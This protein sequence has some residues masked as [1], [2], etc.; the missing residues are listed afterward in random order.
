MPEYC[1]LNDFVGLHQSRKFWIYAIHVLIYTS[2]DNI[3]VLLYN[4]YFCNFSIPEVIGIVYEF[5]LPVRLAL[6]SA[7][8]FLIDLVKYALL[9][10]EDII[11]VITV[12]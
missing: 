8:A 5:D 1:P 10:N 4:L 6:R 11:E 7:S 12:F 2:Y 3:H 9:S